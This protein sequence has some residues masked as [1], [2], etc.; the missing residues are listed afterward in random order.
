MSQDNKEPFILTLEERPAA[1]TEGVEFQFVFKDRKDNFGTRKFKAK[2]SL[3]EGGFGQ[4]WEVSDEEDRIS[5]EKSSY[6]LKIIDAIKIQEKG[7]NI[8]LIAEAHA[9][10][11]GLSNCPQIATLHNCY[12]YDKEGEHI[13]YIVSVRPHQFT[14]M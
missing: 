13:L 4:V 9:L 11:R 1:I 2:K 5:I 8:D 3:G 6:A 12:E 10:A 14:N 7:G